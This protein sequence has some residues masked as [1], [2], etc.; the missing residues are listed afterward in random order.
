MTPL[1]EVIMSY[2]SIKR[3]F[4]EVDTPSS[5]RNSQQVAPITRKEI[6]QNEIEEILLSHILL[7][8]S[9]LMTLLIYASDDITGITGFTPS[10]INFSFQ[11]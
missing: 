2:S 10:S 8:Q 7:K 3:L 4:H 1:F 5:L 6:V 9:R 11:D